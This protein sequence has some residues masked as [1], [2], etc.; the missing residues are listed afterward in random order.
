M[1]RVADFCEKDLNSAIKTATTLIE[2][3]LV[4]FMGVFIGGVVMA[5]L[6]PIFSLSRVISGSG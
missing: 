4:V 3:L 2:P 5:L 6:L 1:N